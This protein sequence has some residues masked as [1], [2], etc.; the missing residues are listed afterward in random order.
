MSLI[1]HRIAS[2]ILWL[3]LLLSHTEIPVFR[4]LRNVP[5]LT[6][7]TSVLD[8]HTY[9]RPAL[10]G[11]QR[12]SGDKR[13]ADIMNG[14]CIWVYCA[15]TYAVS[16][17]DAISTVALI[18]QEDAPSPAFPFIPSRLKCEY[19]WRWQMAVGSMGL[20]DAAFNLVGGGSDKNDG[21]AK[22]K[23]TS[24][25]RDR[26]PNIPAELKGNPYA[27]VM[28]PRVPKCDLDTTGSTGGHLP[29]ASTSG[30]LQASS[31]LLAVLSSSPSTVLPAGQKNPYMDRV[32]K[33]KVLT[34]TMFRDEQGFLGEFVAF[35]KVQGVDKMIMYDHFSTDNYTAE[36]QPWI[37]SGFVDLYSAEVL[38][39]ESTDI[40]NNSPPYWKVRASCIHS[41]ISKARI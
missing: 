13:T 14:V 10:G 37:D 27:N 30:I 2:L 8:A 29:A 6:S 38:I 17:D 19:Q 28:Y 20:A 33:R 35:Y 32:T 18:N 5:C 16:E 41:P 25:D 12:Q 4:L 7:L 3:V 22:P 34:C 15:L 36:L 31:S 1:N 26:N 9:N 23:I 11:Q 39:R 40:K 21:K 24:Q